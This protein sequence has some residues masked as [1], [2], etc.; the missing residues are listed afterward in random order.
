M[1]RTS[2]API[3]GV[4]IGS[5]AAEQAIQRLRNAGF[6]NDQLGILASD[7]QDTPAW[8]RPSESVAIGAL[9]GLGTPSDELSYYQQ[10]YNSG[11]VLVTVEAGDRTAEACSILRSCGAYGASEA[12]EEHAAGSLSYNQPSQGTADGSVRFAES[13]PLNPEAASNAFGRHEMEIPV[14]A[15]DLLDQKSARRSRIS[16]LRGY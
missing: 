14:S 1:R 5:A 3:I 9:L 7:E 13:A 15:D 2:S 6:T 16:D 12:C 4:F 10:E 11:H 8:Q